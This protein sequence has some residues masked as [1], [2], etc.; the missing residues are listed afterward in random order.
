MAVARYGGMK[1]EIYW[2]NVI[3]TLIIIII[4]VII[5]IL[6]VF[7]CKFLSVTNLPLIQYGLK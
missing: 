1:D 5:I 2:G 3:I 6:H 7:Q 4:S